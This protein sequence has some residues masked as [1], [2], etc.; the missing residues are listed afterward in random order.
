MDK[1]PSPPIDSEIIQAECHRGLA[2]NIWHN[3]SCSGFIYIH[4]RGQSIYAHANIE[5][6]IFE[7][8]KSVKVFEHYVGS[9]YSKG[10]GG[11]YWTK[12]LDTQIIPINK[13]DVFYIRRNSH[14]PKPDWLDMTIKLR[15]HIRS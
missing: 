7:N 1:L 8:S 15:E 9:H 5:V 4:S 11:E 13:N 10:L 12:A 3:A 6:F 2:E 14:S